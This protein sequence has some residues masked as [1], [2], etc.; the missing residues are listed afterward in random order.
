MNHLLRL[1]LLIAS[2]LF[3]SAC[4]PKAFRI[5]VPQGNRIDPRQVDAL[6]LG[7]TREQVQSTIGTPVQSTLY[8]EDKW[9]YV[10]SENKAGSPAAVY[11]VIL[12]FNGARLEKIERKQP[13]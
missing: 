2:V 6:E 11:A 5:D 10:A 9:F 8:H 7:M 12:T 3:I 1:S 4:M 13:E